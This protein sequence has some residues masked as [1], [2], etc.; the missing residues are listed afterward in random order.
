MS[1]LRDPEIMV[2][3]SLQEDRKATRFV[4]EY[5]FAATPF[6]VR[7][8]ITQVLD[9]LSDHIAV[10]E[11][12]YALEIVLAEVL[13]NIVE[14]GYAEIDKGRI[15]LKACIDDGILS[16]TLRDNGSPMPGLLPPDPP[17]PSIDVAREDLPEGR[18]GWFMIRELCT[19]L[20]YV[21]TEDTNHLSLKLIS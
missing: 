1:A 8:H 10:P 5:A 7:G 19:D 17:P 21:R 18:F 11:T 9:D 12:K 2:S 14:H 3:P 13:N 4:V 6:A 16:I 20:E 15:Y